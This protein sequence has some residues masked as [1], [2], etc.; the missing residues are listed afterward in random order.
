MPPETVQSF[1]SAYDVFDKDWDEQK[2]DDRVKKSLVDYYTVVSHL[3]SIAQV[4]KMYIPPVLDPSRKFRDNQNLFEELM[5]RDLGARADSRLLDVGCGRGRIAAHVAAYSGAQV[6][7]INIDPSQLEAARQFALSDNLASQCKFVDADLNNTPYPFLDSSFDGI[8]QVQVFSY[9]SDREKVFKELFRILKP[10]GTF[11][12]LDYVLK[13]SFDATNAHH[14]DLV[15]RTKPLL[16]A[17]GSPRVGDY[18]SAMQSAGFEIVT[19]KDLSLNERQ[20]PLI[21]KASGKWIA[22][23]LGLSLLPKHF[24][25]LVER[26]VK[27]G[28][29]FVEADELGILTTSWYFVAKKP[30]S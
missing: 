9:A 5:A 24:R 17:I 11:A 2:Y 29:A 16:G 4:E 14:V 15:R 21:K 19:S 10:G 27:G 12:C 26:F 7:G 8:Y 22:H 3:C 25:V 20:S 30:D 1:L 6:T 18:L 23:P 28:E 13:D